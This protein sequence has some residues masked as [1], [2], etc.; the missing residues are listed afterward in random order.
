MFT[1]TY[2]TVAIGL[3]LLLNS[4]Y[5]ISFMDWRQA[6][7]AELAHCA[8]CDK[9][10]VKT[11]RNICHTCYLE[12]EKMFDKVYAFLRIKE[13]RSATLR[14]VHE[15]TGVPEKTIIRFV[16]EGRLRTAKFTNLTY[17]CDS[18][19]APITSGKLCK[20]CVSKI[21]ADL[22]VA[23]REAERKAKRQKTYFLLEDDE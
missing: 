5:Y 3:S 18:C 9:V 2:P 20:N 1:E 15:A 8:N 12:E 11:I 6:V 7:M 19:G 13:N 4:H 14:E 16:K 23:E 21:E 10:F 17:P 22:E